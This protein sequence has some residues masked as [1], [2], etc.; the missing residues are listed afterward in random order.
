[1]ERPESDN[2]IPNLCKEIIMSSDQVSTS[3]SSSSSS[4]SDVELC[5]DAGS[6]DEAMA[7]STTTTTTIDTTINSHSHFAG[8][9][10][11]G[12]T[13]PVVISKDGVKQ[14]S[15]IMFEFYIQQQK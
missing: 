4:S 11:A 9:Q 7:T 5:L 10:P 15:F 14:V 1:M 12:S 13:L 8:R 6:D 3:S 2:S